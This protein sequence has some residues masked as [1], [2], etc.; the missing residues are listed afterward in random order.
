MS[1][2]ARLQ[3][4]VSRRLVTVRAPTTVFVSHAWK[5]VTGY[6][7]VDDGSVGPRSSI[8]LLAALWQ[9]RVLTLVS[10]VAGFPMLYLCLH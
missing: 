6:R 9:L 8:F 1:V 2:G 5:P 4:G 7:M 10:P 3:C